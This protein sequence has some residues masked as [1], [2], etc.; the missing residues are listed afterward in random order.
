[1]VMVTMLGTNRVLFGRFCHKSGSE[2]FDTA[3]K[4]GTKIKATAIPDIM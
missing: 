1:M 4:Q 2:M 3:I